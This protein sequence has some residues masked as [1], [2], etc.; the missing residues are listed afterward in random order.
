M[1]SIF[2]GEEFAEEWYH[3]TIQ[4]IEFERENRKKAFMF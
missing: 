3:S 1:I 2:A 4:L